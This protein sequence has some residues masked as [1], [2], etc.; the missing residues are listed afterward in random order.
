MVVVRDMVGSAKTDE[1]TRRLRKID[2]EVWKP[3]DF[4]DNKYEISN[5]GRIKSFYGSEEG[6][7]LKCGNVRGYSTIGLKVKG[8]KRQ[9]C[10][11]K[12]IAEYF[13][14]KKSEDEVVVIHKDWNKQNN[15]YKNL[16]W[17]SAKDSYKRMHKKLK[18]DQKREGRTVTNS[19]LK[20][21]D[22]IALKRMLKNGIKQNVIAKLFAISEMQVTRIKRNENWA[23]IKLPEDE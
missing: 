7:V 9:Y 23:H 3:I 8:V 19:K 18:E 2:D 14:P 6:K 10:V 1:D 4:A 22:I 21:E 16:Q 15:Y 17:V 20:A 13:I 12:L 11:H 5:Y